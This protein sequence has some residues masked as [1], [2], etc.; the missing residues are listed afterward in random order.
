MA[1]KKTYKIL[2]IDGGGIR[3]VMP[4]MVMAEIEKRTKK[5]IAELFD[6]IAGNSTGGILALGI[7]K[8]AGKSKTKKTVPAYTAEDAIELYETQGPRIFSRS[9]RSEERRVGK[10]C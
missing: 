3:G 2:S 5:R 7:T 6:L 9:P 4:A 10:E 1:T 8:P